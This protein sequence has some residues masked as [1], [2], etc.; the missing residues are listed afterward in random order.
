LAELLLEKEVI[1]SEDLKKIF[2]KKRGNITKETQAM[3]MKNDSKSSGKKPSSGMTKKK[4]PKKE[5][6]GK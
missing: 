6:P 3:L 4:P 5:E 1:F 2:G